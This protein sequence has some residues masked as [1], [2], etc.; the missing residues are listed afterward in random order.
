MKTNDSWF[1]QKSSIVVKQ[2]GSKYT[3]VKVYLIPREAELVKNKKEVEFALQSIH[4]L[5]R[6]AVLIANFEQISQIVLVFPL[7]TLNE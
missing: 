2:V 4:Q 3:Y 7:L 5:R 1:S 6:S